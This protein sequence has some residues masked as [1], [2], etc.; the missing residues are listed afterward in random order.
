MSYTFAL[1][2]KLRGVTRADATTLLE[3]FA[4]DIAALLDVEAI[5]GGADLTVGEVTI[6][7]EEDDE[8]GDE[9]GEEEEGH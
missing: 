4:N 3:K 9:V 5:G 1:S 7:D 6:T 8:E 2:G